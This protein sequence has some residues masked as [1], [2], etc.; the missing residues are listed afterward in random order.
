MIVEVEYYTVVRCA[1]AGR[2]RSGI[3]VWGKDCSKSLRKGSSIDEIVG[4]VGCYIIARCAMAGHERS[5]IRL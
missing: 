1:L 5:E 3:N 2:E 4:E